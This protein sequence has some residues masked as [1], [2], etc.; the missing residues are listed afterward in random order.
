[1]IRSS[2]FLK[3]QT[4]SA[5]TETIK[6]RL[7][8]ARINLRSDN[9]QIR[10]L[11]EAEIK[12][13]LDTVLKTLY[14]LF[15][16]GYFSSTS[17]RQ[18]RLELCSEATR[19]ALLLTDNSLTN[20][21]QL[22]ALLALM[23]FQSS[24]LIA[25]YNDSNEVILFEEQNKDLWDKSLILRGNYY[26]VNATNGSEISKFHLEA[27]IAYWHTT[28][29]DVNRWEHILQLYNQLILIEYSPIIALNRAFAF[30]RVYG[31]EKAIGEAEKLNLT[32]NSYYH[33]LLGYLYS[34]TNI[35]KSIKHYEEA[36]NLTKSKIVQ[37]T[38]RRKIEL[39]GK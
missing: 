26:L 16:E 1:M 24:R 12:L 11:T 31:H 7:Q 15:N 33:Q 19:L 17:D 13:R 22:N 18:I 2:Y 8:R 28:P 5:K 6:K 10:N 38:L 3:S 36:I 14:L 9:F 4:R 27:G 39:L 29:A 23:C 32:E 37:L 21:A 20:T 30:A 34:D 35:A 25:R